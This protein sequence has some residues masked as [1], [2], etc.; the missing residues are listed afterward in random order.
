[1]MLLA[2]CNFA[3]EQNR[4][5]TRQAVENVA[6]EEAEITF[7]KKVHDVGTLTSGEQVI[8]YYPYTNSGAS[9][10]VIS[11]IRAGCGCTVADWPTEPLETGQEAKIKVRFDSS[12]KRG[13]Q[14][15]SVT[16]L[17]NARNPRVKL[18][19]KAVVKK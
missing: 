7:E 6:G 12:G 11:E 4:E 17:S 1:M 13:V 15:N 10:L 5:F 3:R 14:N 2:A 19:V 9:P 8:C 16:V 18:T